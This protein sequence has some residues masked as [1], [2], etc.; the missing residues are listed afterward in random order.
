LAR[1]FKTAPLL[2]VLALAGCGDD[3]AAS[4]PKAEVA[5]P[6]P[7]APKSESPAP[8]IAIEDHFEVAKAPKE[9]SAPASGATVLA[10]EPGTSKIDFIGSKKVGGAHNGGFKAFHGAAELVPGKP[11]LKSIV[12]D[13]DTPSI[14]SDDPKLTEHLKAKDFFE[15]DKY[16]TAKFVT[17][18]IKPG[19]DKGA[20]HTLVGN[21]TLHGVTKSITIPVVAKV[22]GETLSLTSEF[23]L[24]KDDFGMTFSGPGAV[25]RPDVVI[26]LDVKAAKKG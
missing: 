17:T 2:V 24:N 12:V 15:V 11:E 22:D 26:K 25:I 20:T 9:V 21:L 3:P 19:G 4:V 13:I 18:E 16:P 10:I 1:I 6:K 8:K 14:F 5:A 23:A 7:E